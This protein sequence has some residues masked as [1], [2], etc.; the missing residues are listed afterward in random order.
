M[1]A[2]I[3]H[4]WLLSLFLIVISFP[5]SAARLF[6]DSRGGDDANS[7]MSRGEAWRSLERVNR[8][9]FK[10]GDRVLFVRGSAWSTP[11]VVTAVGGAGRPIVF[12][13]MGRG[14]RPRIDIGGRFEDALVLSNAQQVVVRDFEITNHGAEGAGTNTPP[15]R[16][17]HIIAD[18]SGTLTN[19]VVSDLFIH[20]VNG[21][22]R[23]KHN[24]GIIF[25]TRGRRTPS[26]FEGLRIERNIVWRVDRSGIV[27]ESYHA[28]RTR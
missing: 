15:R 25:S 19:L 1:S 3:L 11:L 6:V 26:R 16:G 23:I 12:E 27:A 24:G 10:P 4:R 17:V 13:A 28:N 20:D 14:P 7:G 8:A 9:E 21:T 5:A 22:Q 2:R 18:N